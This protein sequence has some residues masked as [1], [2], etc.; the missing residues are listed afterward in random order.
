VALSQ[1]GPRTE[2]GIADRSL[3]PSELVPSE[4]EYRT[5]QPLRVCSN[6]SLYAPLLLSMAR[7]ELRGSRCN[8]SG[9]CTQHFTHYGL[10]GGVVAV[11]IMP[12]GAPPLERVMMRLKC[13]IEQM[14]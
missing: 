5:R 4:T 1:T 12:C 13:H 11:A 6:V 10:V 3:K 2:A 9:A 7:G 14:G 8:K